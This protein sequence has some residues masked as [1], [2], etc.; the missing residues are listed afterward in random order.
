M[1]R[2]LIATVLFLS[3]LASAEIVRPTLINGRTANP[4]DF[5]ASVWTRSCTATVVG[6]QAVFIAAHCVSGGSIKF[7]VGPNNYSASCR[8]SREYRGNN[9]ADYAMCE[10]TQPV[11]GIAYESVNLDPARL[12]VGSEVLLT[13][14]GCIRSGGGGGNDGTYRI[15][16]STVIR[17]P[18]GRNNDIVTQDRAAL[19]FGDSGGPAFHIDRATGKRVVISTNSRGDISRTSYLSATHTTEA[20]RFFLAWSQATGKKI[21]GVHSDAMGCRGGGSAPQQS[22]FTIDH[23]LVSLKGTMK[24]GH[25]ADLAAT[26]RTLEDALDNVE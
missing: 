10:T 5:P 9:T 21:C 18:S 3:P 8:V 25:E 7:S 12:R 23:E 4:L 13:G 14:Y 1:N 16:E 2:C 20:K 24:P 17:M 15:G 6:P 22:E 19:C 26:K 11:T